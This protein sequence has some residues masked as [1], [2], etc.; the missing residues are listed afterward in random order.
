MSATRFIP[1]FTTRGEDATSVIVNGTKTGLGSSRLRI[2]CKKQLQT[3]RN[4]CE[5]RDWICAR[6]L[7]EPCCR[8]QVGRC[9][10][11]IF[12]L[13]LA[14]GF[15]FILHDLLSIGWPLLRRQCRYE[16]MAMFSI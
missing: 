8:A 15:E 3:L 16:L 5:R 6:T 4:I 7:W 1:V 10:H 13:P 11:L 14:G 12:S 9:W 2:F